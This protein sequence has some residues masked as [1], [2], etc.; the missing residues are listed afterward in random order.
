MKLQLEWH[1]TE[2]KLRYRVYDR[3]NSIYKT[4]VARITGPHPTYRLNRVFQEMWNNKHQR[5]TSYVCLLD[6]EGVYEITIKRYDLAGHYISRERK[7]LFIHEGRSR[8]CE[9]E[10]I[11]IQYLLYCVWLVGMNNQQILSEAS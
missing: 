5:W 10:A 9:D 2:L 3:K 7:W 6:R 8:E 11:N 4:Y 1:D